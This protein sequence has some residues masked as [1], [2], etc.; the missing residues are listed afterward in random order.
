MCVF[1][2]LITHCALLILDQTKMY[3]IIHTTYTMCKMLQNAPIL[4]QV[5]IV[6]C[7][8]EHGKYFDMQFHLCQRKCIHCSVPI[9]HR[10]F[11]FFLSLFFYSSAFRQCFACFSNWF[12]KIAFLS[13][14]SYRRIWIDSNWSTLGIF[15]PCPWLNVQCPSLYE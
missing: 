3:D 11:P 9:D 10:P 2:W 13:N 4:D 14:L 6:E 1:V 12:Q 5:R 8:W 7:I 15:D